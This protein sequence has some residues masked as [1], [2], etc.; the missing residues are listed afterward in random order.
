MT[1]PTAKGLSEEL[2]LAEIEAQ[3]GSQFHPAVAK[4]FV[5]VRR[6]YDPATVLDA[7]ELGGSSVAL[8]R[9]PVLRPDQAARRSHARGRRLLCH[10]PHRAWNRCAGR[11][12]RRCRRGRHRGAALYLRRR[13]TRRLVARLAVAAAEPASDRAG[14]F[15]NAAAA[16]ASEATWAGLV[17]WDSDALAGRLAFEWG[18][19]APNPEA[20]VSWFL[21][22]ADTD[23][24]VLREHGDALGARGSYLAVPL[25]DGA[26]VTAYLVVGFDEA[27][28]GHVLSALE[29]LPAELRGRLARATPA[30]V[31]LQAAS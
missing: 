3:A 8:L 10:G 13:Q 18:S 11:Y 24:V 14:V 20:L 30:P 7:E 17:E 21:R 5:A 26:A 31:P 1:V 15:A 22:D 16:F 27:P 29:H 6:G 19:E 25:Q 2:A 4:A 12:C 23:E 9:W 28:G